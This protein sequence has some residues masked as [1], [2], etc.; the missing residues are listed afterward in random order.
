MALRGKHYLV[1]S[2]T[3]LGFCCLP[4]Q[5]HFFLVRVGNAAEVRQRLLG[6]GML[7]RD[8]ASFGLP[9]YIRIAPGA[10]KQNRRLVAA[11]TEMA[12]EDRL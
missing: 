10:M 5:A 2:L 8:C 11:M 12:A 9:Q 4:S 3:A 7:V 6:K 1:E